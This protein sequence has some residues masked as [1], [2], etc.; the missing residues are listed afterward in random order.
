MKI[1]LV[2]SPELKIETFHNVVNVLHQYPGPL[3][4]IAI[5]DGGIIPS[6]YQ[7]R[8]WDNASIFNGDKF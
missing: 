8:T 5:E 4:F 7:S 6:S 2:R 1:H 3:E